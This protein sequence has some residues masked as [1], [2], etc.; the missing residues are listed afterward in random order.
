MKVKLTIIALLLTIV[1]CARMG[2]PDG[3]WFDERPPKVVSSIP[4]DGETNVKTKRI[5]IN[6]DEYIKLENAN[7]KV[8]ISPPQTE[9]AE[10]KVQGKR[11]VIDLKDSL[12][13]NTTYT[14]DF[15]DAITDNNEGNPMGNYTFSFSTGAER[16]TM[17][18]SGYVLDYSNL[19]PLKGVLV[20]LYPIDN[21]TTDVFT[22]QPMQRISRT[23]SKGHFVVKGV[24]HG[25]YR[26]YALEDTDNDFIFSQRGEK[27]AFTERIVKPSSKPDIKQDTLWRDS[28]HIATIIQTPYTHFLPDDITLR[29][30]RHPLTDRYMMKTDRREPERIIAV[31]SSGHEE[32]PKINP[33]N[34][35]ISAENILIE[36]SVERDTVI[37]WLRDTAVVNQDSL[38]MTITYAATDSSG[39]LKPQTDTL[40]L[41]PRYSFQKRQKDLERERENWEKQQEKAAKR[42]KEIEYVMPHD[43]LEPKYD[44]QQSINPTDF[45]TIKF[46]KPI[47]SIDTTRINLFIKQD[48]LFVKTNYR[49]LQIGDEEISSRLRPDEQTIANRRSIFIKTDWKQGEQY[50]LET[51]SAAFIDIFGH[52]SMSENKQ[53]KVRKDEEFGRLAIELNYP[54]QDGTMIIQVMNS[55]DKV[56]AEENLINGKASFKHLLPGKVYLRAFID[57]NNNRRIDIGDYF[58]KRQPET[59]FYYPK[60]IEI[61]ERWD[62][63][64]EWNPTAMPLYG[65]KPYGASQKTTGTKQRRVGRNAERAK[66]LGKELPPY[67]L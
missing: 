37:Y 45:L 48:T 40:T 28:L 20:G 35:S 24:K 53:F 42:G 51:D 33:I 7:E 1:G 44:I 50:L 5:I 15:S 12:K 14:I 36:S 4:S 10:I 30:F 31:F 34:F 39:T 64:V 16:D 52:I 57:T 3:G 23:D 47:A 17:E 32:L 11:I 66:Q 41:T 62:T 2:Q 55:S 18:V 8:I 9:P 49:I 54:K 61:R 43:R 46:P 63:S 59:I 56:I 22:S 6:F 29:A 26:V 19:E 58:E 21:D 38:K 25:E 27:V 67:L 13:G 60:E 65:Q